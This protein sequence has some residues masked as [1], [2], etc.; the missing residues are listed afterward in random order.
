MRFFF[1]STIYNCLTEF[2]VFA[3]SQI[4]RVL[5]Q[6]EKVIFCEIENLEEKLCMKFA[7]SY[8]AKVD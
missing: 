2:K 1:L 7:E 5:L 8:K 6:T 4:V 3:P